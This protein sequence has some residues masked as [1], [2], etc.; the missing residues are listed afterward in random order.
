MRNHEGEESMEKPKKRS[1]GRPRGG[2]RFAIRASVS[3]TT[4]MMQEIRA[5]ARTGNS[6]ISETI[7]AILSKGFETGGG[8]DQ[9]VVKLAQSDLHD[10]RKAERNGLVRDVDYAVQEA[11]RHYLSEWLPKY[12]EAKEKTLGNV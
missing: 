2:G 12:L 1:P 3:L 11:I 9:I 5:R 7:R 8:L 10:L 4:D 6:S